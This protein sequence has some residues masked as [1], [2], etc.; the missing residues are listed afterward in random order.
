MGAHQLAELLRARCPPAATSAPSCRRCSTT[1]S[2]RGAASCARTAKAAYATEPWRAGP[3]GLAASEAAQD[4]ALILPLFHEMTEDD[5][6]A[7]VD[8]LSTAC[9]AGARTGRGQG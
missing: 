5:Q 7:V 4:E 8:A 9:A 3:L 1:A 6:D 2:R